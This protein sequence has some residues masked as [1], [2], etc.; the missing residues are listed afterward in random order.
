MTYKIEVSRVRE[1]A[2]GRWEEIFDRLAPRLKSAQLRA[3]KHVACP[4]HGGKDGCRLF[5]DYR[6]NGACVCNTCGSFRDGFATLQWVNGWTFKEALY[7]VAGVLM[8]GIDDDMRLISR[9]PCDKVWRGPVLHVGMHDINRHTA[10][11]FVLRLYDEITEKGVVLLGEDLHA[12]CR[13]HALHPG[14]RIEV[15]KT[16]D[17]VWRDAKG[18]IF[19]HG[20]WQVKVLLSLREEERLAVEHDHQQYLCRWAIRKAWTQAHCVTQ[21]EIEVLPFWKYMTTRQT[22]WHINASLKDIRLDPCAK[23]PETGVAHPAIVAAVRDVKG[24]LVNVHRTL[25]TEDGRKAP[26]A[27][28]KR[29]CKLPEGETISGC[30]IHL[31]QAAPVLGVAEGIET[32]LSVISGMGIPCWSCINAHG[33]KTVQI[34]KGIVKTVLIFADKDKSGTGQ[35]AARE[36]KDRLVVEGLVALIIV[37]PYAIPRGKKGVDWNDLIVV[38]DKYH[39]PFPVRDAKSGK[40]VVPF[41]K[42]IAKRLAIDQKL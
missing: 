4:V 36:L 18:N 28:P 37:I 8:L 25:L 41:D 20:A 21:G 39:S 31:G 32:A 34:P 27:V 35:Q 14:V 42:V 22:R 2:C 23:E 15:K 38:R 11:G 10:A 3:G 7:A 12:A 13:M 30:A 33:L 40:Y 24:R 17:E 26:V 1:A 19:H 29:L 9:E 6:K 16:A 5:L